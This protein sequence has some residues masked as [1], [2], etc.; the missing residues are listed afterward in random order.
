MLILLYTEIHYGLNNGFIQCKRCAN[1]P[2]TYFYQIICLPLL[3]LKQILLS[4]IS[5]SFK[6]PCSPYKHVNCSFGR[7]VLVR[8]KYDTWRWEIRLWC[9]VAPWQR[10]HVCWLVCWSPPCVHSLWNTNNTLLLSKY[11]STNTFI[12]LIVILLKIKPTH[13]TWSWLLYFFLK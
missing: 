2:Q 5:M 12:K 13:K 6:F 3:L 8:I 1:W 9:R 7:M 11:Y 10:C 4:M